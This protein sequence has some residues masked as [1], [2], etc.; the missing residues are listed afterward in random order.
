MRERSIERYRTFCDSLEALKKAKER[1]SSDEFVIS[2]TVQKFSLAFDISWKVMK[3]ICVEYH[4][5]QNFATG[6]PKETLRTSFSAGLI[7]DDTWMDMLKRRND[8]THDYDGE[9]AEESFD[10]IINKYLPLMDEF[11]LRAEKYYA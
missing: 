5:I 9:L 11:R 10:D 6:S 4:E 7:T 2:G 8:L 1:D 3:D